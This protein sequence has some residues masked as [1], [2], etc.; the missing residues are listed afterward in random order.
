MQL[1]TSNYFPKNE[2]WEEDIKA[3]QGLNLS[4]NY[5]YHVR[6]K[7]T[8]VLYLKSDENPYIL[9]LQRKNNIYLMFVEKQIKGKNGVHY[10]THQAFCLETQNYPDAVN[11]VSF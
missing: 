1:Y 6:F 10:Y 9:L 2:T 3:M 4:K 8:N 5:N 11:H 7:Y